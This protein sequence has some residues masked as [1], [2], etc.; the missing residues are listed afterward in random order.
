MNRFEIFEVEADKANH[1]FY[2]VIK[3]NNFTLE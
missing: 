1:F 3:S 2:G